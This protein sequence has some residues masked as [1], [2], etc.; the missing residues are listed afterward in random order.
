MAMC[1]GHATDAILSSAFPVIVIAAADKN[2]KD[3][4]YSLSKWLSA[5][6]PP[7]LPLHLCSM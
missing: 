4:R 6:S 2:I 3:K 1:G 5:T 7:P